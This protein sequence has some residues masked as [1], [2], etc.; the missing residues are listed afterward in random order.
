M[1][2]VRP[3]HDAEGTALQ[4]GERSVRVVSLPH[5]TGAGA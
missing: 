3:P 1:G 4:S 5:V 2:F